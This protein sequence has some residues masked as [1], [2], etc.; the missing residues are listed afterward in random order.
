MSGNRFHGWSPRSPC[1]YCSEPVFRV[2]HGESVN[3]SVL[4][5]YKVRCLLSATHGQVIYSPLQKTGRQAVCVH[6]KVS[7]QPGGG[8]SP[9]AI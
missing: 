6:V 2:F 3:G 9:P 7:L 1:P 5:C 4:G 8:V